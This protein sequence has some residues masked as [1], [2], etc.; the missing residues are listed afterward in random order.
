MTNADFK[1]CKSHTS[2][3]QMLNY[4]LVLRCSTNLALHY[5]RSQF[6]SIILSP[7]FHFCRLYIHPTSIV[8]FLTIYRSSRR[9]FCP[10]AQPVTCRAR[11]YIQSCYPST[12]IA[13]INLPEAY[14][15]SGIALQM[16]K[17]RKALHHL[18]LLPSD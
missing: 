15:P 4:L 1:T 13:W 3:L 14:A 8:R 18:R 6:C 17:P 9:G 2:M 7:S 11:G 5:D 16:I 12:C 10:H